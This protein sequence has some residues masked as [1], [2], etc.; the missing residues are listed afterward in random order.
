[1]VELVKPGDVLAKMVYAIANPVTGHL[2][3]RVG[4]G[5]SRDLIGAD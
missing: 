5:G 4:E 1:V 2:V 3:E